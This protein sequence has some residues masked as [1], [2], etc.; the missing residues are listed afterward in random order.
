MGE[1]TV[2]DLEKAAAIL[3]GDNRYPE[4]ITINY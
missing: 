4:S 2:E 1:L 3:I